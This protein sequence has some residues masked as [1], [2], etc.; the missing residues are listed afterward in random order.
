MTTFRPM[1][2]ADADIF[3]LR[4]PLI[5]Q[6][7]IDGVRAINVNGALTGRSMKPHGNR[8]VS[9]M[10]SKPSFSGFDGEM[11][12]GKDND[13]DLCRRTTSA[14][15][16]YSGEP[17]VRWCVFDII[18][19]NVEVPYEQRLRMLSD[20]VKFINDEYPSVPIKLIT[21]T[22][23]VSEEHLRGYIEHYDKF[24]YEGVI[25]RDPNGYY[26]N[27]RSTVNEQGLL[28]IKKFKDAEAIVLEIV[29]GQTNNN[30]IVKNNLGYT[31]R[32]THSENM[33]PNRM[34]GSLICKDILTGE[35]ITVAAGK[36]T[37]AERQNYFNNRNEI[38][39][40]TIKYKFFEKGIKD[41][42]RFPT[43]QSIRILSD[44]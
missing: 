4:Y 31:D 44:I 23:I 16:S 33:V 9:R 27:G 21:S 20:K 18:V 28:R 36:M 30:E 43:F 11:Y 1:L 2:A 22:L 10:F 3:K 42:P 13:N 35:T 29:E 6:P 24:G 14:L 25:V 8:Y 37:Q 41:K 38:I 19:D 26:K 32:S 12:V 34:V 39:G 17:N 7:K 15:N 40:K 5:A